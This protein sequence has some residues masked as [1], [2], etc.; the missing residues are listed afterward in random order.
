MLTKEEIKKYLSAFR[1]KRVMV[2]GDA[3]IDRIV[4]GKVKRVSPDAPVPLLR[5]EQDIS[6]VGGIGKVIKNIYE[7]GGEVDLLTCIGN[8]YEGKFF[9]K[10]IKKYNIGTKG[11]F[12]FPILTPTIIR[13]K[14]KQQQLLRVEKDYNIPDN[15]L[16]E[17]K[18]K[19]LTFMNERLSRCDA[20]LIL[21][22]G[23]GLLTPFLITQIIEIV[24]DQGKMLIVR[25][26]AGK[27][28]LYN[29]VDLVSM[30]RNEASRAT[31]IENVN[32]TSMRIIG[33]KILHE[34][35]SKSV[36]IPWIEG[37]SYYFQDEKVSKIPSLFNHP[38]KHTSNIG[39]ATLAAISLMLASEFSLEKSAL[40]GHFS[41][42][43]AALRNCVDKKDFL[44]VLD[45]GT[46]C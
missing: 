9:L 6:H 3:S 46:F 44:E 1:N 13:F 5:V 32:E 34:L 17:V 41:G 42:S 2:I 33:K 37:D 7:L 28:Y 27:E 40:M 24:K 38:A 43:I 29:N 26:E 35:S 10:E 11:V 12:Q 39:S 19:L 4:R 31:K 25:P 30:N 22:Y 21:D 15:L 14:T 45:N 18:N 20:V 23:I 8:D 36:F 16:K